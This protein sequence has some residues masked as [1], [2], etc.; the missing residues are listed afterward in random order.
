METNN[1]EYD[2]LVVVLLIWHYMGNNNKTTFS[3]I[4][5]LTKN[6]TKIHLKMHQIAQFSIF[7]EEHAP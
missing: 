3:H 6:L 4:Y 1:H 7:P 2:N 5:C